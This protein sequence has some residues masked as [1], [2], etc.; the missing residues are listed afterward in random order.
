MH[1]LQEKCLLGGHIF[2]EGM[3]YGRACLMGEHAD[4]TVVNPG[5]GGGGEQGACF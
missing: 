5:G 2:W 3:S 1:I 4:S